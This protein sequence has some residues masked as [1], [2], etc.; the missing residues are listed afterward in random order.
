MAFDAKA[1]AGVKDKKDAKAAKYDTSKLDP[2]E[3]EAKKLLADARNVLTDMGGIA[4]RMTGGQIPD[5]VKAANGIEQAGRDI[6]MGLKKLR[7]GGD[8]AKK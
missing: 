2:L 5:F 6:A 1:F 8:W 7:I 3:A 4:S